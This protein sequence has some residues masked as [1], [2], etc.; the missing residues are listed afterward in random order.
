MLEWSQRLVQQMMNFMSFHTANTLSLLVE[1]A[2]FFVKKIFS[3]N[4][5]VL[6]GN[7]SGDENICN[8]FP[9]DSIGNRRFY[10]KWIIIFPIL[11]KNN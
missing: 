4:V 10:G 1:V 3:I 7:R 5:R 2:C 8:E 9:G 11:N 6:G